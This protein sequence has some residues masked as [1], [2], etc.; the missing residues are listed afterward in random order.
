MTK[1]GVRIS[2]KRENFSSRF[3]FIMACL[4]SA[5]GMGNIWLFPYRV[6]QLGGAAFL[7]PYFICVALLGM[8]G[9]VG[10]ITLGR[11]TKTGPLNAYRKAG[12]MR[13]L[14]H[15]GKIGIIPVLGSL[16]T[17]IGYSVVMAWILKYFVSSVTG[18]LMTNNIGESFGELTQS[19]GAVPWHIIVIIL[20]FLMMA[21]GIVKGI[22]RVNKFMMPAFFALFVILAIRVAFLPGAERGYSFLLNPNF[23]ALLRP[24]TW[25]YALG[26]AFFSLS[27]AGTGTVVYGSYLSDKVDV[28]NSA[29]YIAIFDTVAAMVATMV[30]IPTVFAFGMDVNA[31]PPLMF[32]TMPSIFGMI[33]L[34][35]I[36]AIIFF[37]AVAFAGFTS[38]VNLFETPV[39][40]LQTKFGLSRKAAVA[41]VLSFGLAVGVFIEGG[42][43]VSI[44]MDIIS[45][46]IVPFG[47]ILAGVTIYW[48]CGKGYAKKHA[49]IGREKKIGK[50][51]E[52]MGRYVFCG[53]AIIVF[54][55]GVLY[56]GVG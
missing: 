31:G 37:L 9:I 46:Y 39:E 6:G 16:A 45:I 34:G 52:P 8:S 15:Y 30:I 54:I 53:V 13:G 10:E 4:G 49:Q 23:N 33:P 17:A 19:F 22:E 50:L 29:K 55:L 42:D 44:W 25:I 51:F 41:T 11:S 27:L 38:L 35:K 14:K 2:T 5:V 26:Q 56:G 3:G 47:A 36:V 48:I 43:I 32:I 12:E 7:I 1:Q 20:T 18:D 21:F 40:A 28:I 24:N